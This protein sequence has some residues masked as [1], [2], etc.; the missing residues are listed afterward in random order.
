MATQAELNAAAA[1]VADNN[2][3]QIT[4]A[5]DHLA[6]SVEAMDELLGNLPTANGVPDAIRNFIQKVKDQ[7]ASYKQEAEY[8]I[9][10]FPVA[11]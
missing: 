11:E 10:Q 8:L 4:S 3:T 5:R 6:D 1:L 9:N 7:A 2:K